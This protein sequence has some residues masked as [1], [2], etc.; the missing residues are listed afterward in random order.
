MSLTE[1]IPLAAF[2][3]AAIGLLGSPGPAIAALVAVGKVHGGRKGLRFYGGLQI[4]LAAAAAVSA[5]GLVS[6][7]TAVPVLRIGMSV[8][9]GAYL[10]YI[11][12][13]IATAPVGAPTETVEPP[14]GGFVLAG[15]TLGM[16]NPKAYVAF[17]AL[18]APVTLVS[19]DA[20]LDSALKWSV[21]VAVMIIVDLLWLAG[22]VWLGRATLPP[23]AER[24][25]NFVLAASIVAAALL[26]LL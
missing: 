16:T 20:F 19:G 7:V 9:A 22:G 10:L 17:A 23:M 4:G 24:I 2:A 21:V 12:W 14:K 5:A 25:L 13:K 11:A 3:L 18:M 6:L 15:A 8:V 1:S 26:A